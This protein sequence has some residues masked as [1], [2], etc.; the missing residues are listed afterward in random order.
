MSELQPEVL[1]PRYRSKLLDRNTPPHILTLVLI[2]G[3]GALNMN[4]IL[5]S[6][7]AMT[8]WFKT[9]YAVMQLAISAYL[10]MTAVMQL[11]VGPLSDRYGRRSVMIGGLAIFI[12]ATIAAAL[13]TSV[14]MFLAAR[15]VQASIVSGFTLSRA[16]IRDMVPLEQAASMIGY[17]TMGMTLIPMIGPAIGGILQENFGWQSIFWFTAVVGFITF[18]VVVFDL[19]ETNQH[20]STSMGAQFRAYPELLKSRRFW[21]F[22]FSAMF[23]SGTFFAFVGGAPYVA[24]NHLKLSPSSLGLYFGIIAIGYMTG[25]FLSGRFATRTGIFP[26]MIYGAISA[27]IGITLSLLWFE[28][29][30]SHPIGFFGPLLLV[31]MGNGLTLPSANAGM[32]SVRP[33]LAGS[34]AGLGGAIQIGGGAA[35]SV[36]ASVWLTPASGPAPLLILMLVTGIF[37]IAATLYTRNVARQMEMQGKTL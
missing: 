18:I 23:A 6:L 12:L 19:Q 8:A 2:A 4:L 34:A 35:L 5:P 3:M 13:S 32:V 25:N 7:P 20:K 17:V 27:T 1:E 37:G 29:G 36:L 22:T 9:D 28:L 14:E 15:M 24:E 16:I 30:F 11:I 10:A 21:G 31:G 26:M 33:H